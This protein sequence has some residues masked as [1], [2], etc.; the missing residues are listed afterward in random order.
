MPDDK[1]PTRHVPPS[2]ATKEKPG[3]AA[4]LLI[5]RGVIN[6]PGDSAAERIKCNPEKRGNH[7]TVDYIPALRHHE[8]TFYPADDRKPAERA[9]IHETHVGRWDPA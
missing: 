9:Y 4:S 6:I 7:W 1:K 2:L 5:L 8:V 3:I